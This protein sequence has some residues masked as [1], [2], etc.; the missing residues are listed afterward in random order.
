MNKKLNDTLEALQSG[1]DTLQLRERQLATYEIQVRRAKYFLEVSLPLQNGTM[2]ARITGLEA[3]TTSQKEL[4][5][6]QTDRIS[7]VRPLVFF[8]SGL[9]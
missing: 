1:Q 9:R 7:E 4:I 8:A 5:A 2:S 3:Q 6:Q